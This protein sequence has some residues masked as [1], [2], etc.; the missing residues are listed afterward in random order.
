MHRWQHRDRLFGDINPCKNFGR[1]GNTRQA[2]VNNC[3]IQMFKVQMNMIFI[4]SNTAT[5]R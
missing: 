4:F 3:R 2:F 1:F 5:L